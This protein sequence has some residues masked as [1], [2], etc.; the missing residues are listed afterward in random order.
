MRS[1]DAVLR[2]GEVARRTGVAVSTLRAWE[3]RYELLEPQRTE[4]GHRLYSDD[5]V[6]RVRR[7]QGLIDDGWPASAAAREVRSTPSPVTR[8]TTISGEGTGP[9]DEL[10]ELLQQAFDQFDAAATDRVLDDTFARLDAGAALDRVI[11]PALRW[12]GEGW[13]DDP[14]V[15]A[16]EHFASNAIRPRLLRI[17]RTTPAVAGQVAMAAAPETEEHDLSLLAASAVLTVSGWRVHFLGARTPSRALTRFA[18]EL[19]PRV[20]LIGAL[21]RPPAEA[22]LDDLPDLDG[23]IVVLGGDGFRPGDAEVVRNAVVH[24]GALRDLPELVNVT[25]AKRRSAG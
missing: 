15:I 23:A 2:I 6:Q 13:E 12:V 5:D 1:D 10:R 9:A 19:Q 21:T 25:I 11:L 18:D 8:L 7:M 14:R 17:L 4:G 3:R 22:F 16:R 24:D 20:V